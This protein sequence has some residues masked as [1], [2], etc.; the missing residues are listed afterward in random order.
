MVG[1]TDPVMCEVG[2]AA[3]VPRFDGPAL[4]L[5]SRHAH[6]A[7]RPTHDKLP[8]D[9]VVITELPLTAGEKVDHR[10]LDRLVTRT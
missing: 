4:G 8:E 9:L 7:D 10:P 2:V 3:V 1:R 5:A 6:A